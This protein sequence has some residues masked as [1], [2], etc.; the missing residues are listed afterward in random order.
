[1]DNINESQDLEKNLPKKK[2]KI[3]H[4]NADKRWGLFSV[5]ICVNQRLSAVNKKWVGGGGT[6]R[7]QDKLRE[8]Q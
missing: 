4:S 3:Q 7:V 5:F 6:S 2:E 8:L 1:M